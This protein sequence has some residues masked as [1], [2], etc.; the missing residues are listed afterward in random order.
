MKGKKKDYLLTL[1]QNLPPLL[2]KI[3]KLEIMYE[4]EVRTNFKSYLL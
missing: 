1:K 4:S 2:E 3:N